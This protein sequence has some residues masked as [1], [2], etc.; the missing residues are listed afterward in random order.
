MNRRNMLKL[1]DDKTEFI[2]FKSKH[3]VNTFAEQ[4]VQVGG[5]RVGISSKIKNLGV[6]F[7]QTLSMQ[8]HVNTIAKNCFYYL[9]N[10]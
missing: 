9:R 3:N 8:A 10:I 4:N 6:T 5:T 2:V 7:D 1:N